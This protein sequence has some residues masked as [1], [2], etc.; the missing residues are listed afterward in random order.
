MGRCLKSIAMG[1]LSLAAM[2]VPVSAESAAGISPAT[3]NLLRESSYIYT[4]TERKNGERSAAA[5]VWFYYEGG[6]ELFFTTSPDSW[7]AKR[8]AR[9]SP[10][11]V[12]VGGKDGPHFVGK[13]REVRDPALID[14][15]GSAY[16]EKYWIAWMGFF[17]PRS[18]RVT[19]G[20]TKAYIVE[21]GSEQ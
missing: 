16:N 3:Q 11:F 21:L 1:A 14:R 5:P 12:W 17:R 6:N 9:G 15:M 13:A 2:V 10:V 8:I 4:A 18:D 19:T 20:K 7:K